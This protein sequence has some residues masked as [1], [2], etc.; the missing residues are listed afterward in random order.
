MKKILTCAILLGL[1]TNVMASDASNLE[2]ADS[3]TIKSKNAELEKE[4]QMHREAE[5]KYYIKEK[6]EE[7]ELNSL[8]NYIKRIQL[9]IKKIN[10]ESELKNS[11]HYLNINALLKEVEDDRPNLFT[12]YNI[13]YTYDIS[14]VANICSGLSN[15]IKTEDIKN[16]FYNGC[17]S[18]LSSQNS[19]L[20]LDKETKS[21]TPV[22]YFD[23]KNLNDKCMKMVYQTYH[24]S[25]NL[26]FDSK[27]KNNNVSTEAFNELYKVCMSGVKDFELTYFPK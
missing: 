23:V 13:V 8:S 15:E 4:I 11:N 19:I 6:A 17:L 10:T 24:F 7:F 25:T 18:T 3:I 16:V 2:S 5:F 9:T 20:E 27:L 12:D 22:H 1:S 26:D 21:S 14:N